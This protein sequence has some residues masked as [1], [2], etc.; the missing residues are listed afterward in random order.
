MKEP[1]DRRTDI[2]EFTYSDGQSK[3]SDIKA[4][5]VE[6]IATADDKV[7][8]TEPSTPTHTI[9]P[10]NKVEHTLSGHL[11]EI[12][13]TPGAERIMQ[14]HKSGTFYE[15]HPDGKKVTKIFGDDFYIVLDD[16]NLVVGGNLNI[17]V[18]GNA[19]LLVKG[20]M[21]TKVDGDYNLTVHGNMST[22]VFGNNV[23]YSKGNT[24]IQSNSNLRL[25]STAKMQFNAVGGFE[26]Q[27]AGN[28]TF[29]SNGTNRTYSDGRMYIDSG[30]RV[31]INLPSSKPSDINLIDKDPGGGLSVPDSVIEPSFDVMKAT[32]TDN[33][34]LKSAISS[35]LT[36]PKDRT[37]HS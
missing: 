2:P 34:S 30:T 9:Y 5:R 7:N 32:R 20:D 37:R 12:D 16:K 15:I 28:M 1:I 8:I 17:T 33:N 26:A 14:M 10:Y 6:T 35:Q 23:M 22:R 3:Q 19:N 21:K 27:T 13:D 36:Y 18:Q 31:D 24:D 11:F 25:R 29:N 4:T